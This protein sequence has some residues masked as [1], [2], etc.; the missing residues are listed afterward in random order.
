MENAEDIFNQLLWQYEAGVDEVVSEQAGLANWKGRATPPL[1]AASKTGLAA[2]PQQVF[3]VKRIETNV[4]VS[5]PTFT[6]KVTAS[7]IEELQKEIE[8]F[9]GCPI[10]HTAMNT[11]FAK[12]N[13]KAD[14][15]FVGEAPGADEDRQGVPFVGLS[16]QLLD[17]MLASIGLD[18]EKAY[19]S[20]ILFWRPPG[21]RTPTEAEIAACL[22]FAEQHIALVNPK[23]IVPLGGVAAKTLLRRKDG[24][25]RLRGRWQ[26]Y[27]PHLGR[28][29]STP[30]RCIP[31]FHP[32]Y[33]LRQASA[34]RQAWAD[35]LMIKEA[36]KN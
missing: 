12:G 25:T 17:R 35:L 2:A 9:E 19:I 28:T 14:I 8:A 29:D 15:M 26:D 18:W 1:E 22:P 16:G 33:L 7:S 32:A 13:P 5:A 20:N 6:H 36:L 27:T 34:K 4:S 23:I 24:I 11:V 10:K 30:L 21:N 31:T 3:H